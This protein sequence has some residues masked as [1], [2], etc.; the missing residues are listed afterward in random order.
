VDRMN[1]EI[2]IHFNQI[3]LQAIQRCFDVMNAVKQSAVPQYNE[4]SETVEQLHS[5]ERKFI[6]GVSIDERSRDRNLVSAE[7]VANY[8]RHA[9]YALCDPALKQMKKVEVGE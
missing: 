8:A 1:N 3:I 5:A 7:S 4:L 9:G 2:A 6:M